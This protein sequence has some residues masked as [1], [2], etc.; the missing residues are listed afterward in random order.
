MPTEPI[1][2]VIIPI[3]NLEKYAAECLRSIASQKTTFPFEVLAGDD[4]S[5]DRT[6]AIIK[7][8]EKEFPGVVR[9]VAGEKNGGI[10]ANVERCEAVARGQYVAY[11]GGDDI[12][13]HPLKL[14]KQVD[15]LEQHPDYGLVYSDF[16]KLVNGKIEGVQ[17]KTT[18]V[19]HPSGKVTEELLMRNFIGALTAC[20]RRD[21]LSS[22]HQF[23][24]FAPCKVEDYPRW[25]HASHR[26]LV[27]YLDEPLATYRVLSTS[28]NNNHRKRL[29]LD[30]TVWDMKLAFARH[31]GVSGQVMERMLQG[32]NLNLLTF[33]L[34]AGNRAIFVNEYRD[35][36]RYNPQWIRRPHNRVRAWLMLAGFSRLVR[37]LQ[38]SV[39]P[40]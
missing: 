20:M 23:P 9:L 40:R 16:F 25:L 30:I 34:L 11:C 18:G 17:Y 31:I 39:A 22:F 10:V 35:M 4:A 19:P 12:W 8:F 13:S 27:G 32:R 29:P 28:S 5:T 14:Q 33:S 7:E 37:F 21:L 6:P 24:F 3:Y 26:S 36:K 2:S 1:V 15:F 38:S